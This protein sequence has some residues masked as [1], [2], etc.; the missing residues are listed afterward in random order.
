[1]SDPTDY[2]YPLPAIVLTVCTEQQAVFLQ[3][4]SHLMVVPEEAAETLSIM[5]V[6]GEFFMA[7]DDPND[8]GGQHAPFT[9]L[10]GG[11]K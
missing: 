9:V 3:H 10:D 1:M 4:G 6:L 11:K 5:E 2:V 8:Q 7:M